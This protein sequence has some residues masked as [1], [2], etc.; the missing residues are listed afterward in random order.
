MMDNA[1]HHVVMV[2]M[3]I[4]TQIFL[5]V[6]KVSEKQY[7]FKHDGKYA[8]KVFLVSCQNIVT[9]DTKADEVCDKIEIESSL[10]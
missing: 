3:S 6:L 7:I 9:I 8:E 2:Y 5:W 10:K 1:K 4:T